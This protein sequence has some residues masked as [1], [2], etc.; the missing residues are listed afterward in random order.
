MYAVYRILPYT[1]ASY[2]AQRPPCDT[3]HI[4]PTEYTRRPLCSL[5][6]FSPSPLFAYPH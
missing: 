3:K 2:L 6:L 5:A 1:I 4:Y